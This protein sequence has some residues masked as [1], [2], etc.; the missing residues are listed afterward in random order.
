MY[1]T[2]VEIGPFGKNDIVQKTTSSF[3]PFELEIFDSTPK[4]VSSLYVRPYFFLPKLKAAF[5]MKKMIIVYV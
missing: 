4:N 3:L 1:P 5:S 2:K